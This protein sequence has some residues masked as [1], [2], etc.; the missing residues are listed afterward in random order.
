[1]PDGRRHDLL[2]RGGPVRAVAAFG[3]RRM[4]VTGDL[5]PTAALAASRTLGP[6]PMTVDF[7]GTGSLVTNANTR[8][9]WAFGDGVTAEGPLPVH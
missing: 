2:G 9:V 8:F 5:Q 4:P 6:V 3:L 1:M 7:D